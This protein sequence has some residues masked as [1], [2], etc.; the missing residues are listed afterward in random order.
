[1]RAIEAGDVVEYLRE[2]GRIPR[3][4]AARAEAMGGGVS[5]VVLRVE[6]EGEPP[7]V[8][9][10]ARERLRTEMLWVSRLDRI[11]HE[12]AA[13]E[14]LAGLL[15]T[16][17]VPRVLFEER[18]DF[19]FAMEHAPAGA[20]PWKQELLDGR[21]DPEVARRAGAILGAMHAAT[22]GQPALA[23]AP[24]SETDLFDQLRIDPYYRTAARAHP[25]LATTLDALIASMAVPG[26][27]FV[28]A[29]F[30]PKNILVHDDGLMVVDFETAHAGDPA[31]DL[32]FFTSHLILKALRAGPGVGSY[33]DL[34]RA[35]LDS[36]RDRSCAG[37]GDDLER[38]SVR[39]AAACVLARVDG[40]SPVEYL[41]VPA[42][43]RARA[44]ARDALRDG[45]DTWRELLD[46]AAR[47][48]QTR[49]LSGPG[50]GGKPR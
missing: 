34:A 40:K 39:H 33:L 44:L 31:F 4:K 38:R 3:A 42:R 27:T 36:Y 46:R 12:T 45:I 8:V 47:G 22:A 5:N 41:D 29:D 26:P 14:L 1:M 20:V 28:H 30:S 17:A 2:K 10:Q 35:F 7:F 9:K 16:G 48:M 11:W 23:A 15:P 37:I 13:L 18:D 6:V 50:D 21:A 19:L 32:G 25:D 49:L 43:G 24:L